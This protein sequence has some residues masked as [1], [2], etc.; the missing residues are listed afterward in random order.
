MFSKIFSAAA[1]LA[2]ATAAPSFTSEVVKP[3]EHNLK[4]ELECKG[5]TQFVGAGLNQLLKALEGGVPASCG[6]LCTKAFSNNVE[7]EICAGLCTIGGLY[8]FINL[9]DTVDISPLWLCIEIDACPKTTCTKNCA[10][11]SNFQ[12]SP[13]LVTP[14]QEQKIDVEYDITFAQGVGTITTLAQWAQGTGKNASTWGVDGETLIV[15][16][17]AGTPYHVKLSSSTEI[18][19]GQGA[20]PACPT[21][22]T[23]TSTAIVCEGQCGDVF[24][25]SGPVL[26][27][28]RGPALDV[29]KSPQCQF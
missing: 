26:D 29:K 14:S 24:K 15:G 7:V 6:A 2:T 1:L 4:G 3:V 20:P 9:L 12:V 11:I 16:P 5:C 28:A 17:T 10:K 22:G 21:P 13:A 19:Q 8:E 18:Q 27:A 23:Y 25:T